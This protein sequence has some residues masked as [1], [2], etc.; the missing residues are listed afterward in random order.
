MGGKDEI[1]DSN[2]GLSRG[3]LRLEANA[4][5]RPRGHAAIRRHDENRRVVCSVLDGSPQKDGDTLMITYAN[6]QNTNSII[7]EKGRV[8]RRRESD[9][10]GVAQS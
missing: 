2:E 7:I 5:D 9:V 1:L 3:G 6:K 10:R 8:V 4:H